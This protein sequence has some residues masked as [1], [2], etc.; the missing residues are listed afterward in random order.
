M[1]SF[2]YPTLGFHIIFCLSLIDTIF[3]YL[4]PSTWVYDSFVVFSLV[5]LTLGQIIDFSPF[6]LPCVL[7]N[8]YKLSMWRCFCYV[9]QVLIAGVYIFISRNKKIRKSFNFFFDFL[10]DPAIIYQYGVQFPGNFFFA[11]LISTFVSLWFEKT[12]SMI[13][14]FWTFKL[15]PMTCSI[16]ENVPC[17]VENV[18]S[19]YEV[20]RVLTVY[21]IQ[22]FQFFIQG[23]CFFSEVL[24]D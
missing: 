3:N 23:L 20:W 10:F 19:F 24:L 18:Y 17:A 8:S 9:L 16:L 13:F 14:I 1:Y 4:L 5:S 15:C 21:Q 11:T 2:K 6:F 7:L 12:H 22:L